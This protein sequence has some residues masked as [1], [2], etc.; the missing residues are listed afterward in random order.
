MKIE[1]KMNSEKLDP[2]KN[3]STNDDSNDDEPIDS[4]DIEVI[5]VNPD[6][7]PEGRHTHN[8]GK[9]HAD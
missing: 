2:I 6:Q 1:S 8:T 3:K 7:L 5:E 4:E 9:C